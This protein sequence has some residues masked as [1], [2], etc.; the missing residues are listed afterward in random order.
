M[1]KLGAQ[2]MTASLQLRVTVLWTVTAHP[3]PLPQS[4]GSGGHA[5]GDS[6]VVIS[7]QKLNHSLNL[8]THRH[9]PCASA[10][11]PL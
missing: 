1:E 10:F 11:A 2:P 5:D 3:S 6:R 9:E 7:R 8:R 4:Q